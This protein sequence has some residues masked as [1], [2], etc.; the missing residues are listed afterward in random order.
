MQKLIATCLF[1][2][3]GSSAFA[4]SKVNSTTPDNGAIVTSVPE[5]IEL[6]FA[7][8]VRLTKVTATH[9]GHANVELDL[10][11]QKSFQKTATIPLK[12]FG[13]GTYK[14]EWR[15]LGTD[16]HALK[17]NFSFEVTE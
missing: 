2:A 6:I 3:L 10:E 5:T 14:I 15:A 13:A 11:G 17:G 8:K 4:H 1:I 12:T 7:K 16:G 9:K